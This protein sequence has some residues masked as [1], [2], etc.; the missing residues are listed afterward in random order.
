MTTL[1]TG[2]NG[3]VGANLVRALLA[4]ERDVRVLL[5]RNDS[6][7]EGL[8]ITRCYGDVRDPDSLARAMDGVTI[9]HHLVAKISLD[10]TGHDEMMCINGEGTQNV[11]AAC[12]SAKVNRLI[13][14]SSIHALSFHPKTTPVDESRALALSDAHLAY[15]RSKA[16]GEQAVF[17]GVQRGLDAVVLNPVGMIGPYDFQPSQMGELLLKLA[18]GMLPGLVA[19]GF[20]WVDVRDICMAA[21]A[22]ETSGTSGERY[23]LHGT[24][25]RMKEIARI[26]ATHTGTPA[27][28]LNTPL[29]MAGMAAP[30]AERWSRWSGQ[31]PLF[32]RESVQVLS[33]HQDIQTTKAAD[34]LGFQSRPLTETLTDTIDWFREIG[35]I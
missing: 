15:D 27:P 16:H 33:C 9:V 6:A 35:A 30:F 23:I 34:V 5:H 24:Y 25:A 32:T 20:Y 13:H 2:A 4:Q 21:I 26:V 11:V 31:R 14:Y 12:L 10:G 7:L 19:A 18:H 1:I 28:R 17:A 3:L 29:W 8:P 22:A